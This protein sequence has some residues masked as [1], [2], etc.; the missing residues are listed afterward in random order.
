MVYK[1]AMPIIDL[2]IPVSYLA[3]GCDETVVDT[4]A[5]ELTKNA[6]LAGGATSDRVAIRLSEIGEWVTK[7]TDKFKTHAF[8]D[9]YDAHMTVIR[10]AA[11][12]A[13]ADLFIHARAAAARARAQPHMK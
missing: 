9:A 6:G 4:K 13:A 7:E 1:H 2:T 3:G 10:V 12:R 8:D 5:L 11:A